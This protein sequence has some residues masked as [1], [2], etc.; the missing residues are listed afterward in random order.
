MRERGPEG[1]PESICCLGGPEIIAAPMLTT[2]MTD[3]G[4]MCT[5][6][7]STFRQEMCILE[8]NRVK[9]NFVQTN[10]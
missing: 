3:C 10:N 4:I 6:V 5:E 8:I 7:S 1:G 9:T 2:L